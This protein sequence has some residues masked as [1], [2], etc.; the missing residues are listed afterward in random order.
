MASLV[1]SHILYSLIAA[2]DA[3]LQEGVAWN[4]LQRRGQT[5]AS[6]IVGTVLMVIVVLINLAIFVPLSFV[7]LYTLHSL[8]PTLAIVEAADSPPDYEFVASDDFESAN[9]GNVNRIAA[10]K[11]LSIVAGISANGEGPSASSLREETTRTPSSQPGPLAVSILPTFRLLRDS[12]GGS[13]RGGLTRACKWRVYATLGTAAIMGIT[14]SAIPYFPLSAASILASL[15]VTKLETAWVHGAI[16]TQPD[17]ALWAHLPDYVLI[18]KATAF[19]IFAKALALELIKCVILLMLDPRSGSSDY[20]GLIPRYTQA[21]VWV[22]L[23]ALAV[24]LALY[25]LFIVPAEVILTRTRAS[26]LPN[27]TNT[28]V[29]LDVSIQ[30]YNPEDMGCWSWMHS[31]EKLSR[32]SWIRIAKI[33]TKIYLT[34]VA[35]EVLSVALIACE[36]LLVSLVNMALTPSGARA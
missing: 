29:P 17:R 22:L 3:A 21:N 4:S 15:A 9:S 14:M 5:E 16:S 25:T 12:T 11:G 1:I 8:Y 20:F 19:P 27:D 33:Y 7:V 23:V 6:D 32:E 26:M 10:S 28:L 24:Y 36:M 35:V 30:S 18:L 34:T 2:R 13:W 31:W